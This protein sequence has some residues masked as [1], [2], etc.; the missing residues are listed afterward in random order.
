[1]PPRPHAQVHRLCQCLV[2][3][4]LPDTVT[5]NQVSLIARVSTPSLPVGKVMLLAA[6]APLV[7]VSESTVRKEAATIAG[8]GGEHFRLGGTGRETR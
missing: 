5:Q 7:A 6:V 4:A 8:K 1:M 2:A 3:G